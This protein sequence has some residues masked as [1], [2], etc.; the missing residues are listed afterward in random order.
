MVSSNSP[1]QVSADVDGD[2]VVLR[3]S[4]DEYVRWRA[5]RW[6]TGVAG[7]FFF[8]LL[9]L[10]LFSALFVTLWSVSEDLFGGGV[11][12]VYVH[13]RSGLF[14]FVDGW[15]LVHADGSSLDSVRWTWW[16]EFGHLVWFRELSDAERAEYSELFA[17][18]RREDFVDY[19]FTG[20]YGMESAEEDF[21]E[22]FAASVSCSFDSSGLLG[23]RAGFFGE[24]VAPFIND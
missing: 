4:Q 11:S 17:S 1:N 23:G 19:E 9:Y 18:L 24:R 7:V 3:L 20:L 5:Y 2:V 12:G 16:H 13:D 10:F 8:G 6:R 14:S 21:A 22:S 15:V